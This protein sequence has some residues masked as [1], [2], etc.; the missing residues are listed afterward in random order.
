[1]L[2]RPTPR[3]TPRNYDIHVGMG[4][5]GHYIIIITN[6]NIVCFLNLI[7]IK[8][9]IQWVSTYSLLDIRLGFRYPN[10][11]MGPGYTGP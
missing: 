7:I 5:I 2:F 11:M 1:M 6:I 4:L 8:I 9:I 3:T 10:G